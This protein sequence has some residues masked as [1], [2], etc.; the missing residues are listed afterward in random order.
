M[1]YVTLKCNTN[2]EILDEPPFTIRTKKEH[3]VVNTYNVTGGYRGVFID[4]K[5]YLLQKLVAQQFIP[6]PDNKPL[7][8]F[9]D[10]NP[11]NLTLSNL[12]Y[13]T[14]SEIIKA[15]YSRGTRKQC[16]RKNE[17]TS[18]SIV[19]NSNIESSSEF[20]GFI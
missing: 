15:Q 9:I 8:R 1:S 16:K 12:A 11:S 19:E 18:I 3:K 7:V 17:H 2:Y 5:R 6:N 14:R 4:Y 20:E 10:G 13:A